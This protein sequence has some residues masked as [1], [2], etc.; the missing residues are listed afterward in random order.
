MTLP[1]VTAD[2]IARAKV[3]IGC[4]LD[5]EQVSQWLVAHEADKAEVKRLR[6]YPEAIAAVRAKYPVDVF[7]D[8]NVAARMA[9]LT[10]DNID[11]WA[12]EAAK[13]AKE[14]SDATRNPD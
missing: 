11:E 7:P 10:C 3:M 13:A 14:E 12:K 5:L 4:G 2:H 9:R 1:E 8:T 6:F